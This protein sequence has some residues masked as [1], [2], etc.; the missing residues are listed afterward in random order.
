MSK[1]RLR[2]IERKNIAKFQSFNLISFWESWKR[3][4]YED[5]IEVNSGKD[6]KH[7]D[8]GDIPVYGGYMHSVSEAIT[9]KRWV[10]IGKKRNNK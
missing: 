1:K 2:I 7:L 10:G 5:V 3:L 6:Y 4:K 9:N 8:K